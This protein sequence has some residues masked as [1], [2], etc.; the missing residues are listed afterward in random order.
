M[1]PEPVKL[2]IQTAY[3]DFLANKSLKPR[4]GQKQMIAHIARALGDIQLCADNIRA[5]DAGVAVVEAGTGTG[6]TVAYLIGTIAYALAQKKKV[7]VSTATI[8]LQ[9]QILLKDL[10]DVKTHSGLKFE[11]VLAKGRRRYLCLFKLDQ[12]IQLHQGVTQNNALFEDHLTMD[13]KELSKLNDMLL[14]YGSGKWNGEYE[15]W[16]GSIEEQEWSDLTSNHQECTRNRCPMFSNCALFKAREKLED[17]DVIVANHDLLLSDL[18]MGGG[19]ILSSPKDTIY[20]I[21][22]GHHLA[23]KALDHFA[24]ELSIKATQASLDQA[25]KI[26]GNL[27]PVMALDDSLHKL[28]DP[29]FKDIQIASEYM[30]GLRYLLE[31]MTGN[32]Y[33]SMTI[34]VTKQTLETESLHHE[35]YDQ[36]GMLKGVFSKIVS[37]FESIQKVLKE[38]LSEQGND[39]AKDHAES[40]L[41]VIGRLLFRFTACMELCF[42]F[43]KEDKEGHPPQARWV[44]KVVFNEF[45][46][47]HIKCSPIVASGLLD[48]VFWKPSFSVI[49]TS[50]T[51]TVGQKFDQIISRAGIPDYA[52]FHQVESPFQYD[53]QVRF[54]VP[55][56]AVEANFVENHTASLIEAMETILEKDNANLVLFSSRKQMNEVFDGL[57]AQWQ[58]IILK[59]NQMPKNQIITEHQTLIDG[60]GGST[61]FGLASFAEGVD[62]PGKYL[63]HLMI[64][65]IPFSTPDDPISAQLSQWIE[66]NGGNAFMSITVPDAA[67][68]LVQACGRLI[69]TEQDT[70]YIYLMDKRLQTKR[71]GATL[72]ASLPN[73]G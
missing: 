71:Y 2:S 12:L 26:Q 45:N 13:E 43:T 52:H 59:Q 10:P 67:I 4:L 6:K 37:I 21:D 16:E 5:N 19:T 39:I 73:F 33:E 58:S 31:S 25:K 28:A 48:Y 41:P 50:A 46:D 24:A 62:L 61:I 11:Y 7:V 27:K 18:S 29:L 64:A 66:E 55:D 70:G 9:E 68:R 69:R 8:A 40:W 42:A 3:R 1:L 15:S 56:I 65:K 47:M 17:A 23:E 44:E 35:L 34:R 14:K 60:G 36:I 49:L 22:E 30:L 63:T 51:L 57:S 32:Q 20:I 53:R 54:S 72:R 38:S